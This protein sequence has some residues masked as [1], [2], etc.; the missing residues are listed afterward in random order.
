L[1]KEEISLCSPSNNIAIINVYI[2][3]VRTINVPMVVRSS[4]P[5]SSAWKKCE[6]EN[7]KRDAFIGTDTLRKKKVKQFF[8]PLVT[9]EKMVTY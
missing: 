4:K 3:P 7:M 1:E 9:P 6:N 5:V 2:I 8:Q